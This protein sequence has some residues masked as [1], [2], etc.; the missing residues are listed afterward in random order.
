MGT[1]LVLQLLSCSVAQLRVS[2]S[3]F[4]GVQDAAPCASITAC[5]SGASGTWEA[6]Q[7]LSAD[8]LGDRS[9]RFIVMFPSLHCPIISRNVSFSF[10]NESK[11]A[12]EGLRAS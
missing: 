12:L 5:F 9:L 4:W 6:D 8:L 1:S 11:Y 2:P 7:S 3:A 10:W